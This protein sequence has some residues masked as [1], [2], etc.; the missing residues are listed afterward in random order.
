MKKIIFI[1]IIVF[2]SACGVN[3][4]TNSDKDEIR[5]QV[6]EYKKQVDELNEKI[7]DLEKQLSSNPG[8]KVY[9]IPVSVKELKYEPFNHYIEVN[10]TV[11]AVNEAFVSPE[12]NGQVQKIFVREGERV[13]KG[14]L[15]I[16]LNSSITESSIKEVETGLE[17]AN[18]VYERQKRLYD[19]NIGSEIDYLTAKNNKEALESKLKT[20]QA[21]QNMTLI[22][23]PF[24]G[25]VDEI[26]VKEG[27]MAMPGMQ[28]IQVV[29]LDNLYINADVSE[30]YLTKVRKGDMVLL[31]FPSYPDVKIEA[32]VYRIGNVVKAAN[33]TFKVQ[34]KI[35]NENEEIKPN[36]LAIININDFSAG[37]SLLV[38]SLV[39]KQ[40]LKGSYVYVAQ[41]SSSNLAAK[42]K[43]VTTG[44]SYGDKSMITEGLQIGDS[45]IISGYNQVSDG[46]EVEIK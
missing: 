31:E 42:K 25:I 5:K 3:N 27:E 20:L 10:G 39:I 12:I 1:S 24:D 21:Q 35:K 44:M 8:N 13:K 17:F 28:T 41:S 15:L 33:R 32:P 4:N 2:L 11:E 37:S 34:L 7:A 9:K 36:V 46:A 38:P 6:S 19:K 40:D 18:T 29:N 26:F 14:Q 43:Y 16:K 45:V 23:A 22:K 30:A